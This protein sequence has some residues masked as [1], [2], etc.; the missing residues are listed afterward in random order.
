[1]LGEKLWNDTSL[2]TNGLSCNACHQ[3]NALFQPSFKQPYPHPVKMANDR[4]GM[5]TIDMDEMVQICLVVPMATKTMPW[6][7]KELAALTAYTGV[8]QKGYHMAAVN[9]CAAN[10][11]AANPCAAKNPCAANPCAANPCAAK[12]PCAV[13]PCAAN[14]CAAKNPCAANPCAANPCAAKNPCGN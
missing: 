3:G 4:A 1:M 8:V 10:P 7:S 14:P 9:P 12:N 2:S 13:N 11:C 5:K 6:D